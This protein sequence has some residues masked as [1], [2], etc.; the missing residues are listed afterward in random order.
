MFA[1]LNGTPTKAPAFLAFRS[2]KI[3]IVGSI[4]AA[5]FTDLFLYGLV[6][7]VLPFALSSKAH[8]HEHEVQKW[9][10]IL[11]A[12]YGGALFIACPFCGWYADN[13]K[14]R[15]TPLLL[16]LLALAGATGILTIGNSITILIVGRALQGVS[17]AVVWVVGLAL[18]A[19]TVGS[20]GV[21][22]AMGYLGISMSVG[23]LVSP[24]VG[25]VVFK[26]AGYF[27]VFAVSFGLL[28]IDIILRLTL[29]EKSVAEQWLVKEDNDSVH[30]QDEPATIERIATRPKLKAAGPS[31]DSVTALPSLHNETHS[32]DGDSV[33]DSVSIPTERKLPTM[34]ILLKSR[35]LLS[36]CIG[37]MVQSIVLT[38]FDSTVPIFVH[39]TFHWDSV[40]A[41]LVFLPLAL[42]AFIAPVVGAISDRYGPRYLT[43]GGFLAVAPLEILLRLI[44]HDSLEQKVIFLVLLTLLGVSLT[45]ALIPV[46]AEVTYCV[47]SVVKQHPKGFFGANGAYAQAYGLFNMAFAAGSMLG[48]LLGGLIVQSAGWGTAS[49][50]L[51]ILS[52]VWAFPTWYWT[53]GSWGRQRRLKKEKKESRRSPS[54]RSH[55][56]DGDE[57]G[58]VV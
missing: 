32:Q 57:H 40:G 13:S 27:A 45:F 41:G 19:D 53:G 30:E 58:L 48:P 16:G 4:A 47:E 22:E 10:S 43:A 55:D 42:P 18:V 6:V 1:W 52:G 46:M 28:A 8:V 49:L 11:L 3:F 5:V 26:K 56:D 20:E 7:P 35:R 50:V 23:T 37:C 29:I 33:Q 15:K 44:T 31:S 21:G 34:L 25:G 12:V 24:L 51:G 14:S 17:A 2:S 36:S 38:A 39:K 9:V 54:Q